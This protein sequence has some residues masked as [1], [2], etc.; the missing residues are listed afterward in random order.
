MMNNN[1]FDLKMKKYFKTDTYIPESTKAKINE[2]IEKNR[3]IT[4]ENK[5]T[6]KRTKFVS[7]FSSLCVVLFLNIN[8]YAYSNNLPNIFSL[9]INSL[10]I[11]SEVY[12][13]EKIV[14]D[15][16]INREITLNDYA[17]N[18]E[19]LIVNFIYKA[20]DSIYQNLSITED[21]Y[22][23]LAIY[24]GRTQEEITNVDEEGC[25]PS[26]TITSKS[27]YIGNNEYAI[28]KIYNMNEL[29]IKDNKINLTVTDIL[30][31]NYEKSINEVFILNIDNSKKTNFKTYNLDSNIIDLNL[32]KIDKELELSEYYKPQFEI[33]S[34]VECKLLTLVEISSNF[35]LG[36]LEEQFEDG[37][38]TYSSPT[39]SFEITDE[40][41][42]TLNSKESQMLTLNLD[43][44]LEFLII[45]SLENSNILNI[46][47]YEDNTNTLIGEKQVT[48]NKQ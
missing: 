24:E 3:N 35:D 5:K 7:V 13:N 28:T 34:I 2:T 20:D 33:L 40:N 37:T 14:V 22:P 41:G 4:F 27:T 30:G 44:K 32:D 12:E 31:I 1:E 23:L 18:D 47:V 21:I 45:D 36:I 43:S 25:I 8:V 46:K 15:E 26:Y 29:F 48:I 9:I 39:Y 11:N 17:Y 16:N 38:A 6:F 42:K 19:V 10:N